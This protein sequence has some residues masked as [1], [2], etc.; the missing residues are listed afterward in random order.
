MIDPQDPPCQGP[1]S[2][3]W[4]PL[5]TSFD[6]IRYGAT[7]VDGEFRTCQ[8]VVGGALG[9]EHS[10]VHSSPRARTC[11]PEC[12]SVCTLSASMHEHTCVHMSTHVYTR[13]CG[14]PTVGAEAEPMTPGHHTWAACPEPT[15]GPSWGKGV[16]SA[17][18]LRVWNL[19]FQGRVI[20]DSSLAA[21]GLERPQRRACAGPCGVQF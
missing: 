14:L 18:S 16:H 12:T 15:H 21:R 6:D 9:Q 7:I 4:R 17:H 5:S 19:G 11:V 3:R 13:V 20:N 2:S 8:C 10:P 1:T